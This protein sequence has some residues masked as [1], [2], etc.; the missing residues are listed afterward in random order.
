MRTEGKLC[1]KRK[2]SSVESATF[3]AM[4]HCDFCGAR[5]HNKATCPT[6]TK[7]KILTPS[8]RDL[9]KTVPCGNSQIVYEMVDPIARIM[10]WVCKLR[11]LP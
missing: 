8:T 5:G 3:G 10:Q 1:N 9:I 6:A 2:K 4:K 7:G 11:M